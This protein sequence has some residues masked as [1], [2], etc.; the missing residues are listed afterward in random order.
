MGVRRSTKPSAQ[1]ASSGPVTARASM[2]MAN[3]AP[4]WAP[5]NP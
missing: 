5:L 4:I 2:G 3:R 1:T